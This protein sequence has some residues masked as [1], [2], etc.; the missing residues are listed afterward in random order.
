MRWPAVLSSRW[1]LTIR[2]ILS[3]AIRRPGT[4]YRIPDNSRTHWHSVGMINC[5]GTGMAAH[6]AALFCAVRTAR[7]LAQDNK[8]GPPQRLGQPLRRQP[9]Q[10][11]TA[12]AARLATLIK[13]QRAGQRRGDLRGTGGGQVR[14]ESGGRRNRLGHGV[15]PALF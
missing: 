8:A 4:T 2:K 15:T 3:R 7:G 11:L 9:G 14:R 10:H 13:A 12:G 5:I 6:R 1:N